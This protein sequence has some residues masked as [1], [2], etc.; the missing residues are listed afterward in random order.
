[1]KIGQVTKEK[2]LLL[3]TNGKKV[4]IEARGWEHFKQPGP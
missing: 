1:M 3:K 4:S 2:N